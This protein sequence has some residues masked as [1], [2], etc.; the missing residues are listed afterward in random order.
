VDDTS[1]DNSPVHGS[2]TVR[3]D[4]SPDEVFALLTD[5]DELPKLSPENQRCEFLE[6]SSEVAVGARFRGTNRAGDYEWHA[7]CE[8]T[9]FE[10]GRRF[11]YLVPPGFEHA[12]EW[13]YTIEPDAD[14]SIVTE[15]FHAPLLGLPDIYP[16]KIEGRRDNLEKACQITMANLKSAL[17]G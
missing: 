12:T 16:G 2:A 13:S 8:V 11:V 14:G 10:P 7:D 5:L 9:V 4:A 15:A 3:I 6:G 17:E 1:N